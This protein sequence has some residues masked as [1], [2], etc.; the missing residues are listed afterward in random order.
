LFS[1][2]YTKVV[3]WASHK[4]APYFLAGVSFVE[5]S[6]F[7]IPPDVMLV[8]MVLG[9]PLQAWYYAF[10][11]TVASV[12]GGLFGYM[13]GY[14]AFDAFGSVIIEYFGYEA[15]YSQVVGW[16]TTYGWIA[17]LVAAITPIPYKVFT[18]A[19]GALRMPIL[20][21]VLASIIGRAIRFFLVAA[22]VKTVGKK[23]EAKLLK[24]IN[25]IGWGLL[26]FC[27]IAYLGYYVS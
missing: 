3:R 24:Y 18:L 7:P 26:I 1:H 22:L 17:V 21:F 12:L 2:I 27:A 19:A 11:S 16:F 9:K 8:P 6:I 5:S 13:L 14:F 10:I 23:L 25:H 15:Q 20:G 4:R